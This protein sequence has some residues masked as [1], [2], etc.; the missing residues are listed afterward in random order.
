[1]KELFLKI[2]N[3]QFKKFSFK[4]L[5]L[6]KLEIKPLKDKNLITELNFKSL[7]GKLKI[8]NISQTFLVD[9]QSKNELK[10]KLFHVIFTAMFP[11]FYIFLSKKQMLLVTIPVFIAVIIVDFYRYRIVLFGKVF[12]ALFGNILR[13][14]ELEEDNW[15][16]ISAMSVAA[17]IIYLICPKTIAICAFFILA[18][19]DC[20]AALV[21][22]TMTS[23]EFFEKSAAGSM[24]FGISSFVILLICGI[25]SNQGWGYYLFGL[26]AVFATTI[27]EARPSFINLDDNLTIP[28]TFSIIMM[29]FG[30]MWSL[31]Y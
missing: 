13:K 15:T 12:N 18:F 8:K 29:F 3:F 28:L 7:I 10:R 1:M 20:L 14:K 24:V 4:K 19:S 16:S 26:F 2:K 21:G 5:N 31:N 22:E 27:I 25:L 23:K 30:I 6:D 11:L 17:I 9:E